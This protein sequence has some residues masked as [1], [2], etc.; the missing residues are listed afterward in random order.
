MVALPV[1]CLLA[2][3]SIVQAQQAAIDPLA[4]I[5]GKTIQSKYNADFG[6]TDALPVVP[7]RLEAS[8]L[9]AQKCMFP[10]NVKDFGCEAGVQMFSMVMEDCQTPWV[11]CYCPTSDATPDEIISA[12]GLIPI[13]LR[14]H[15]EKL[16]VYPSTSQA[17][18]DTLGLYSTNEVFVVDQA[19]VTDSLHVYLHESMHAA[20]EE[21]RYSKSPEWAAA[22]R[23][24]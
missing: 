14:R 1:A 19:G 21:G 13:G 9:A 24:R 20:D 6:L 18:V 22:Y 4:K 2:V 8:S 15:I 16:H 5:E 3:F 7:G 17:P 10:G 12:F 11:L 23:R